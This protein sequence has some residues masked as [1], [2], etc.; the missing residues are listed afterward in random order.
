MIPKVIHYCW[1]GGNQLPESV[2]KCIDSW[3]KLCAGYEIVEWNENNFDIRC[4][5]YVEEA[6]N[7]KKWAFV[8]DYARLSIIYNEGGIYFD[9]DVELIKNIDDLRSSTAFFAQEVGGMIATGLGFGAEKENRIIKL[10]M[11]EY[12]EATFISDEGE[13][14]LLPCPLRNTKVLFEL[15]YRKN[16]KTQIV[17]NAKIYAPDFFCPYDYV[18][19]KLNITENTY[20]IHHYDG[21]WDYSSEI[22]NN[23]KVFYRCFG[24]HIGHFICEIGE[25]VKNEGA[26]KAVRFIQYRVKSKIKKAWLSNEKINYKTKRHRTD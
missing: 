18:R 12:E 16:G 10:M 6:Y 1:F 17:M 11:D 3:K 15:G 25:K 14:D 13:L 4:N 24:H 8:S 7:K 21:S 23:Y 26:S 9:T 5:Q 20:S 19:N 22:Q 2:L